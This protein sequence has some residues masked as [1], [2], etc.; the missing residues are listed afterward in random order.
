MEKETTG[1]EGQCSSIGLV[2]DV[3]GE[4]GAG[5]LP[6]VLP[7]QRGSEV[8]A[9]APTPETDAAQWGHGKV[10]TDF[11]RRLER[12]RDVLAAK[13]KSLTSPAV[14]GVLGR[15]ARPPED[16]ITAMRENL[17]ILD[18]VKQE[19]DEARAEAARLRDAVD[20]IHEDW[21]DARIEAD[22][23]RQHLKT[24][25]QAGDQWRACAEGLAASLRTTPHY[26]CG[27]L[28]HAADERHSWKDVCPVA[29]RNADALAEF[30]RLKGKEGA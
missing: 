19:R 16:D 12:E 28:D 6:S 7:V 29:T 5:A 30:D 24:S 9:E 26:E 13:V 4:V 14:A 8:S 3:L 27:E 22:T 21:K 10:T 18:R 11:A 17:K 15:M 1:I 23:L 25:E 20:K 2:P